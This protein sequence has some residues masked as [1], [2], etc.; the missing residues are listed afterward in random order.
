MPVGAEL[1][2]GFA[3]LE[4]ALDVEG[5]LLLLLLAGAELGVGVSSVVT[6]VVSG[7]TTRFTVVVSGTVIGSVIG[8]VIAPT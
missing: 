3:L 8:S 2:L 6:G 5:A 7:A 1:V 4:G